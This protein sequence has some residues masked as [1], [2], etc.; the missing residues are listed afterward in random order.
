MSMWKCFSMAISSILSNKLRSVLTMLGIII[1]IT[2]VIGLVSLMSGLTNEVTSAFEEMG[3]ESISV[4]ITDR[5]ATKEL[6]VEDMQQ[7]AE[8]NPD[9]IAAQSP[10][11]SMPAIIKNGSDTINSQAT[12]VNEYYLGMRGLDIAYGRELTY[13]DIERRQKVCVIGTYIAQECF[14][15]DALGQT[16][17]ITGTPYEVVG[18]IEEQDDSTE[19]STDNAVY[20]PY[21]LALHTTRTNKVTGYVVYATNQET[22][23][24]AVDLL[25]ALCDEDIGDDD[26]YDVTS[27][28]SMTDSMTEVLDKMELMLIAIAGISL[29]VAGIGIMNIMLV[30][31][32]ERTR[33]IGIRKSLG[34][35]QKNILVQFVMEAGMLSCIGGVIGIIIGSALAI[36][37]GRILGMTVWPTTSSVVVAFTVSAAIGVF[38]GYMPAKKAAAL[39]PIDALRYD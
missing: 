32:T 23:E 29:V 12:G 13:I 24:E 26:Y 33:E 39:N 11:V 38:F 25:E 36:V 4:S 2:A 19:S 30:S 22:V 21:T 15:G 5:G 7:L 1:G 16:L 28:K 17:Q 31:V 3:I 14:G 20:V 8:D 34:A 10:S 18:I 27:M 9:I 6:P 35:K 37:A